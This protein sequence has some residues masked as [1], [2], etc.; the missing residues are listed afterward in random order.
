M[1]YSN[2]SDYLDWESGDKDISTQEIGNTGRKT[3]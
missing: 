2:G 3:A 1:T